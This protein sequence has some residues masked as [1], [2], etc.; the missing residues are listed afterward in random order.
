MVPPPKHEPR[1][2]V[3]VVVVVD[4]EAHLAKILINH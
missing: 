2:A 4:K 3:V 1:V